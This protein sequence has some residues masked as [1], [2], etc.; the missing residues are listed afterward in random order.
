MNW[1]ARYLSGRLY[2]VAKVIS[3]H[4]KRGQVLCVHGVLYA[5]QKFHDGTAVLIPKIG[6]FDGRV[7]GV[8][9]PSDITKTL[10]IKDDIFLRQLA[11]SLPGR[12][13]PCWYIYDCVLIG[14]VSE[15]AE[16][17]FGGTV[18]SVQLAIMFI[19]PP[20]EVLST[21]IAIVFGDGGDRNLQVE[22]I[23]MDIVQD[24]QYRR[25][26]GLPRWRKSE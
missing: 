25:P 8:S 24:G 10:R 20:S 26:G 2:P 17:G 15:D 3:L 22:G 21:R 16:R 11:Q 7:E 1:H 6:D 4:D 14:G 23:D 5:E 9:D 12:S 13:G 18:H 19:Q